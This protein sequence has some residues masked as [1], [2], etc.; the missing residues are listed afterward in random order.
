MT[1]ERQTHGFVRAQRVDIDAWINAQRFSAYQGMILILLLMVV[2]LDG[3]DAVAMGFIAPV[4]MKAWHISQ[5][6]MAPLLSASM[7]GLMGG[8]LLSG[9]CADRFG[10]R[11]V[12]IAATLVF[13][14]GSL[15]SAWSGSLTMLLAMRLITGMGLGAA[16]PNAATLVAEYGPERSRSLLVTT[17]MCGFTLGS[18]LAG[19]LAAQLIPAYG[20]QSMLVVGGAVPIVLAA[21]LALL[22]P[23]SVRFLAV[24]RASS[25]RIARVLNRIKPGSFPLAQ[26][27]GIEFFAPERPLGKSPVTAILQAPFGVGT[28]LLWLTC[29][30]GFWVVYLLAAWLPTLIRDAGYSI[31]DAARVTALFQLGG[32]VGAPFVGWCMDR[33]RPQWVISAAYL[34]AAVLVFFVGR[35]YATIGWM[36]ILVFTAGFFMSGAQTSMS[37]LAA[38]FY[39]TRAR[40]TGVSWMQGIGRLGAVAGTMVGG[41]LLAANWGFPA[42]FTMLAGLAL[43]AAMTTF[44]KGMIYRGAPPAMLPARHP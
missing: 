6:Q 44:A 20:W 1:G 11:L 5:A 27:E 3:F 4:L 34:C 32:T 35:Y 30:L 14:I 19:L 24:R 7:L 18:G 40:S 16:M 41:S 31:G 15:G 13:G 28:L 17:M 42:I 25:M 12:V 29:F 38:G 21:L 22:L 33:M 23:E 8:A 2:L 9:P 36:Q 26:L 39:P 37:P 10:R 43:L